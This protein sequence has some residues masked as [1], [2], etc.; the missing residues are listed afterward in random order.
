MVPRMTEI[1]K[2]FMPPTRDAVAREQRRSIL[3]AITAVALSGDQ[4]SP[5]KIVSRAWPT[6]NL[7]ALIIKTAV[8]PMTLASSGL[9]AAVSIDVLPSIAPMSAAVR[10]FA[11]CMRVN[12]DGVNQVSV[13]RGLNATTPIFIAEGAPAPV[14][15]LS[16]PNSLIGPAR[17]ILVLA[18]VTSELE[19]AGPEVASDIIARVISE[20]TTRSLD[21]VVFDNV[22]ANAARPAGLLNG[23]SPQT[24]STSTGLAAIAADLGNLAGAIA[25]NNVDADDLIIV[26]NPK[27]AT[28]I[29]FLAQPGFDNNTVFSSSQ[30]PAGR[31]IGI[32]ASAVASAYS[33]IPMIEKS[34]HPALHFEDS[35]PLNIATPGTPP[36]V[37]VPVIS[38][39]QTDMIAIKVRCRASWG[40]V[41]PGVA[42]VDSVN[43]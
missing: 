22:A 20:A 38:A 25:A 24:A 16:F 12:L 32:A 30:I 5:D 17:K 42:Y 26:A 1:R 33:E 27:Q 14:V 15:K 18:A 37:A 29:R 40:T 13:P 28:P 43:W 31:V 8:A 10:M 9:P 6:D 36:T 35:T 21:A 11:R 7:A 3:R 23:L 2:P 34:I 4:G 39:F 41:A 19:N